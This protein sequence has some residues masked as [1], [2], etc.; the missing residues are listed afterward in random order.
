MDDTDRSKLNHLDLSQG[1]TVVWEGP[2]RSFAKLSSAIRCVI[3]E[4]ANESNI[5]PAITIFESPYLLEIEQIEYVYKSRL[6]I[7]K[8]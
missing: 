6:P 7:E 5:P 4:V 3:E 2:D 1:A 8:K